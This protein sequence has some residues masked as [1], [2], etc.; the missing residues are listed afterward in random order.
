MPISVLWNRIVETWWERAPIV[1]AAAVQG[2]GKKKR[3]LATS[4]DLQ[5]TKSAV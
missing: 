5:D 2:E 3:R 1:A 4:N